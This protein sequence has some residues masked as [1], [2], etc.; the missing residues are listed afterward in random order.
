MPVCMPRTRTP[1]PESVDAGRVARGFTLLE[2]MIALGILAIVLLSVYRLHSQTIAM[3]IESRFTTQAPILAR[4]ALARW[5]D[6][7]RP[8]P[9]SDQ[10]DFGREFPGYRWEITAT[11][12]ISPSLGTEISRD[13]RRVDVRVSLNAGEY[14]YGFRTYRFKRE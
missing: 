7:T 8:Q 2:V 6:P 12:V 10:G 14:V 1:S 5:E 4:S 13:L 11:E 9:A 3:S